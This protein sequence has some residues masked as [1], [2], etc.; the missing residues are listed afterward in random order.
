M[1][2]GIRADFQMATPTAQERELQWKAAQCV[3]IGERIAR[4]VH[5]AECNTAAARFRFQ[6]KFSSCAS[7]K[8]AKHS[9]TRLSSFWLSSIE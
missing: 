8:C 6:V 3:R 1:D 4:G 5:R 7:W 2:L 9:A